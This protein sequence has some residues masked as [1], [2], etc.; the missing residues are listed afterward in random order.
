MAEEWN[1]YLCRVDDKPASIFLDLAVH[2]EAPIRAFGQLG[3]IHVFMRRPR[4]DGLSSSEEFE[5]LAQIGDVLAEA[6]AALAGRHV[7]RLTTDGM[8]TFYFY[9]ADASAFEAAVTATMRRFPEYEFETGQRDDPDW[10][11]YRDFLYPGPV[12]RQRI[13]NRN[14]VNVL[15]DRGDKPQIPRPIE[16]WAHFPDERGAAA[17]AAWL[18]ARDFTI[19]A[20]EPVEPARHLVRFMRVDQPSGIDDVVL[21]LHAR[22]EELGGEYDGWECQLIAPRED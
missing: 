15:L 5:T 10:S 18:Q 13:A 7:G 1:F 14:V 22:A 9:G 2:D 3:Y 21:P 11:I 16:H 12:D 6:T 4:P 20:S 8:R 17:F 19:T